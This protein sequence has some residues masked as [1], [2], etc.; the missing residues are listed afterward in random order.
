[1]LPGGFAD[2]GDQGGE[3]ILAGEIVQKVK[4]GPKEGRGKHVK[5]VSAPAKPEHVHSSFRLYGAGAFCAGFLAYICGEAG[6]KNNLAFSGVA[7][8]S[9]VCYNT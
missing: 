4:G 6:K 5:E 9:G 1:M 7:G 8:P 3:G 2:R